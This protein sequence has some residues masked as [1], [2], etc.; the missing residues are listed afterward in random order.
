LAVLGTAVVLVALPWAGVPVWRSLEVFVP[1][2]PLIAVI[3]LAWFVFQMCLAPRL[4][5]KKLQRMRVRQ[6]RRH[7]LA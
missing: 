3:T 2:I 6:G 5:L 4:R 1:L 7:P